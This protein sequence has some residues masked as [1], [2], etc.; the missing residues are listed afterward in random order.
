M[1][2]NRMNLSKGFKKERYRATPWATLIM[3]PCSTG[4]GK[5]FPK[6]SLHVRDG[7]CLNLKS[8]LR[9][10]TLYFETSMKSSQWWTE[11]TITCINTCW[12]SLEHLARE[13]ALVHDLRDE[14]LRRELRRRLSTTSIPSSSAVSALRLIH[15]SSSKTELHCSSA[16]HAVQHGR[17]NSDSTLITVYWGR[18]WGW[19][20]KNV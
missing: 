16:K 4:H 14:S 11:T 9:V 17:S 6:K 2:K 8:W 19:F 20:L 13:T 7:A 15:T 3:S 12:M 18:P 1:S 10:K 5:T